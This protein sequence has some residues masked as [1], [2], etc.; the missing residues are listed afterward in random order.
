MNLFS[1]SAFAVNEVDYANEETDVSIEELNYSI[2][3]DTSKEDKKIQSTASSTS[4]SFYAPLGGT[5]VLDY[6]GETNPLGQ[7]IFTK[8]V[9]LNN[10]YTL[11]LQ[12]AFSSNKT[13]EIIEFLVDQGASAVTETI[14]KKIADILNKSHLDFVGLIGFS[15]EVMIFVLSNLAK[16]DFE[17]AIEESTT[18]R[19]K[20]E[21]FYS[22]NPA[23]PY[24]LSVRN[25]EPWNDTYVT[26][27]AN[28]E[29][30]WESNCFALNELSDSCQ[31]QYGD[32]SYGDANNHIKMCKK[33][34]YIVPLPHEYADE[35]VSADVNKH[36]KKCTYCGYVSPTGLHRFTWTSLGASQ[37]SGFCS[38]CEY[39]RI[40]KHSSSYDQVAGRCKT[41]GYSG[42][43]QLNSKFS[44]D[45]TLRE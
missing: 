23:P 33:C 14:V 11:L 1:L 28:Y 25:F 12:S 35:L 15:I 20:V 29:Y 38:V 8:V 4:H 43:I 30:S 17:T 16:W 42:P 44:T 31:H 39:T 27:P 41:C 26:V 40:E 34:G 3:L 22:V 7:V 36:G 5:L 2:T 13:E 21:F 9:Y 45:M 24:Y 37:H 18:G 6:I 32:F 19:V 10:E